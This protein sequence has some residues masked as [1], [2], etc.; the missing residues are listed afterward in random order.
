M[1]EVGSV[2]VGSESHSFDN[3][4]V[5]DVFRNDLAHLGEMPSVPFLF[6]L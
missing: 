6:Q 5:G 1:R 4:C 2:V 3:L